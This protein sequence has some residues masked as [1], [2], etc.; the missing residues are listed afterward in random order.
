MKFDSTKICYSRLKY[1]MKFENFLK[2]GI[3]QRVNVQLKYIL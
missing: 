3:I 1:L 2:L